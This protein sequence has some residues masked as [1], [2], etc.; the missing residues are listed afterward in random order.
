MAKITKRCDRG[1]DPLQ[2]SQ[3]FTQADAGAGDIL[4]IA[5][6]LGKPAKHLTVDATAAVTL[7]INVLRTVYPAQPDAGGAIQNPRLDLENPQEVEDTS[8]ALFDL[9]AGETLILDNEMP[10][11]DLKLVTVGGNFEIYVT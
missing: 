8:G 5:D 4:M 2:R 3:S 7:R 6:S 1:V 11:T 10:V 9:S